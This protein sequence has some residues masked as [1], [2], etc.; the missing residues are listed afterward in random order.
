VSRIY[1]DI[2]AYVFI[3]YSLFFIFLFLGLLSLLYFFSFVWKRGKKVARPFC[4]F[5]IL[6]VI[7]LLLPDFALALLFGLMMA[8]S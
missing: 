4:H 8:F 5:I 2:S 7:I 3:V 1:D 6:F